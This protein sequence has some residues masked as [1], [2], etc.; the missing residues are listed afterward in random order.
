MKKW[1]TRPRH[2]LICSHR[3]VRLVEFCC[4]P[5]PNDLD[6]KYGFYDFTGSVALSFLYRTFW[7]LFRKSLILIIIRLAP[8]IIQLSSVKQL[9][10]EVPQSIQ[11][12]RQIGAVNP[13]E[14][15]E[16]Q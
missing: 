1:F 3:Q 5:L 6:W 4:L 11:E 14:F 8:L 9:T 16:Q 12:D 15:N 2:C 13:P 7:S 10:Q